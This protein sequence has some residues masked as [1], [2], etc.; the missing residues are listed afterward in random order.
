MGV[1]AE[2]AINGAGLRVGEGAIHDAW[3]HAS[4]IRGAVIEEADN[5]FG[6]SIDHGDDIVEKEFADADQDG[7]AL[8]EVVELV[9]V[10]GEVALAAEIPDIAPV[11]RDAD[12]VRHNVR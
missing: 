9:S 7:I 6:G 12:Q 5:G 10:D 4:P 3:G 2:D 1:S 11:D 8:H